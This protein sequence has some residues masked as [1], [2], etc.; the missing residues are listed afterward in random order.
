VAHKRHAVLQGK[1][2]RLNIMMTITFNVLKETGTDLFSYIQHQNDYSITGTLK[3]INDK[4]IS[5]SKDNVYLEPSYLHWKGFSVNL[6]TR[7]NDLAET[8]QLLDKL[9][10]LSQV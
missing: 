5:L 1:T 2:E 10:D 4:V 7:D 8:I 9:P 6:S 3:E